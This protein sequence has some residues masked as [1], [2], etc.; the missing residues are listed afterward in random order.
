M[1]IFGSYDSFSGILAPKNGLIRYGDSIPTPNKEYFSLWGPRDD[2]ITKVCSTL[3]KVL[4]I[5]TT[6]NEPTLLGRIRLGEG[7]VEEK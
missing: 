7:N 6:S 2:S 3:P 1:R 4:G 5:K